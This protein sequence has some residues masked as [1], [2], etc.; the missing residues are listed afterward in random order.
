MG[1]LSLVFS[2]LSSHIPGADTCHCCIWRV[3][4]RYDVLVPSYLPPVHTH[5]RSSHAFVFFSRRTDRERSPLLACAFALGI[6]L[7]YV[8]STYEDVIVWREDE[9]T[10]DSD[11][12]VD[13]IGFPATVAAQAA[14]V[15]TVIRLLVMYYP[16]KRTRWGR[17]M[18]EKILIRTLGLALVLMEIA[19]WSAAY[20]QGAAR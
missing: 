17:Y 18:K 16:K 15:M 1:L 9:G 8:V 6:I 2:Q 12:V 10:I 3:V 19:V 4:F 7:R 5:T 13:L 11:G 14:L 20:S